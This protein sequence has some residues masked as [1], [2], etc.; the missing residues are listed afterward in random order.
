MQVREGTKGNDAEGAK[1]GA[2]EY[3]AG[4]VILLVRLAYEPIEFGEETLPHQ[5][6]RFGYW[7]P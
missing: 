4:N 3:Q 2:L 5:G 6:C 7:E 1:L